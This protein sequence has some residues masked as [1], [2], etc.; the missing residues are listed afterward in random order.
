MTKKS[1]Y[2]ISDAAIQNEEMELNTY[3][4]NKVNIPHDQFGDYSFSWRKLWAFT[5]P[6]FLMSIAYLDP[7]NIESDMQTGVIAN[8]RLLWVLLYSTILGLLMQILS[9]RMGVVTGKHLAELCYSRYHKMPRLLLWIMTE[10]AII[11]SDMQEVIGTALALYMLTNRWLPLWAGVLLTILDTVT[12]L[13]LDKYGLRKLETFFAFLIA[14]M[15]MTFGYEFVRAKPDAGKI[16]LGMALPY[17][18]DCDKDVLLQAV[19]IVGAII[20]PHNLYL[21]SALVKSRNVDNRK[22]LEAKDANRYILIE[23]ITFGYE[24]FVVRPDIGGIATGSALPYCKG[25]SKDALLQAVGIVGAIIQPHNLYLHS[26]LVKS[27]KVNNRKRLETKDAN[28]YIAIESAI[29]LFISLLINMAVISVFAKGLYGKTNHDVYEVCE[30]QKSKRF[31]D[32]NV[33]SNDNRTFV[34]DL[35]QAGIFLG[36]QFGELPYYIWAIGI[37]AAGQSSTMTGT[38]AGQFAM[39]GFLNLKWPRWKRVLLT[40]S[41]AIAPTFLVTI[42]SNVQSLTGMNDYLNALMVIQLP[43]AILP[44]LTFSSSIMVMGKFVNNLFNLIIATTLSIVVIVVNIYFAIQLI[45]DKSGHYVTCGSVLKLMNVNSGIRLHSHD[46]K[47]G[48]GSGQQSVTG[49]DKQEDVNSYWQIGA[50]TDEQCERGTP[51]EC[52]SII[53]L[54]HLQTK[55]NLHSHH[56][57][58]P[59]SHNQEVSAFGKDGDGDTGD[60]WQILCGGKHWE[61]NSN[62]RFKHVDTEMYLSS[63]GHVYGRPIQGQMEIIASTYSDSSV[64]WIAKEG[65][66]VKPNNFD[67]KYV[68]HDEL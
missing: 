50:K 38:Y 21:H 59:L 36:C 65:I 4:N 20:M 52:G 37:L 51:I 64:Y 29:V 45:V 57:P 11:G 16:G 61:L 35:Y 3:F 46:I 30:R 26:A 5:G 17:C 2:S 41:I 1:R 13:F 34:A 63:S 43:F 39:E 12:F 27:R 48:S 31:I 53:R 60:N 7:G 49:T 42:F 14:I 58:S 23:S 28:R 24:F 62:I 18:K 15:A 40:R 9:A 22:R 68:G 55:K 19:G 67:T 10:I 8:Y 44:T 6:G 56:F 47:Y 54:T 32:M 33:L 25:C 66:F